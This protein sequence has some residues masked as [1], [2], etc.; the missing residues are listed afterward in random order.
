MNEIALKLEAAK[1][2][3]PYVIEKERYQMAID[4]INRLQARLN[5]LLGDDDP[6]DWKKTIYPGE[7]WHADEDG[8]TVRVFC[9]YAQVFKA[10]KRGTQYEEY[11]PN[12]ELLKWMLRVMNEAERRGDSSPPAVCLKDV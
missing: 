9:E 6:E 7:P 4:E 11:W 12:P 8:T 10:P 5:E 1:A 2:T 3:A